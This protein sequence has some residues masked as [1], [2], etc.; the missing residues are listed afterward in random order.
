[1]RKSVQMSAIKRLATVVFIVDLVAGLHTARRGC[2]KKMIKLK[3]N[4]SETDI[5]SYV[6]SRSASLLMIN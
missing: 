6:L 4:A 3:M 5:V 1:M 2:C